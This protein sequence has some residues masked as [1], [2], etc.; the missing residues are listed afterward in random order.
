MIHYLHR[1]NICKDNEHDRS[2]FLFRTC[3]HCYTDLA[4]LWEY[5]QSV[6]QCYGTFYDKRHGE[7]KSGYSVLNYS[8][9][10]RAK[11]DSFYLDLSSLVLGVKSEFDYDDY[12]G[13]AMNDTELMKKLM[14][15][16]LVW[17]LTKEDCSEQDE[18]YKQYKEYQP[19]SDRAFE[20]DF[21]EDCGDDCGLPNGHY[22]LDE[23]SF[24]TYVEYLKSQQY[25]NVLEIKKEIDEFKTMK[26]CPICGGQ[27]SACYSA[28]PYIPDDSTESQALEICYEE[29]LMQT[30]SAKIS[31]C[32]TA[33]ENFVSDILNA[34]GIVISTKDTK[35]FDTNDLKKYVKNALSIEKLVLEITERL[36]SVYQEF[37]IAETEAFAAKKIRAFDSAKKRDVLQKEYENALNRDFVP[38]ISLEDVP[39]KLPDRPIEP[40]APAKPVFKEAGLFNKKKI[41]AENEMLND[42]Y[43]KKIE[44]YNKAREKYLNDME[45][46]TRTVDELMQERKRKYE[47]LVE[48]EKE[49]YQQKINELKVQLDE[50]QARLD[51]CGEMQEMPEGTKYNLLKPEKEEAEELLIKAVKLRAELYSCDIIFEKYRDI[52]SMAMFCEYLESG[53]C[54]ELLGPDGAYNLYENE[55]RMNMIVSQLNQ[56]IE[57]L[58]QIKNNQFLIYSALQTMNAQL[59]KLNTSMDKAVKSLS[60]IETDVAHID[61]T[62]EIIAYNTE[63]TAYYSQKNAELTN[64]LGYMV[65]LS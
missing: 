8:N 45:I 5:P 59:S 25:F 41:A 47:E 11:E 22:Y 18:D 56:V 43:L 62:A 30:E 12:S 60:N 2:V 37:Y 23:F 24:E 6:I 28:E 53:R 15:F 46:H 35:L 42:T 61:E 20:E 31:L 52:V 16:G 50:E 58:E 10:S 17:Q 51:S 19:A 1:K 39:I 21:E 32:K 34:N 57:S 4:G 63:R 7:M 26:R 55:I 14:T 33:T 36:K 13:I 65:A 49:Q 27:L 64:A 38:T 44:E 40:T 29:I 48:K 3:E 54:L 9:F